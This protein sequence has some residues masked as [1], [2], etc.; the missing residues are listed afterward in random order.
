MHSPVKYPKIVSTYVHIVPIY[1]YVVVYYTQNMNTFI[2]KYF[3][4]ATY[5]DCLFRLWPITNATLLDMIVSAVKEG[6][7]LQSALLLLLHVYNK[8]CTTMSKW[9]W[10]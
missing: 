5:T 6:E 10:L 8:Y 3:L 2:H 9:A 7:A 1:T 4:V